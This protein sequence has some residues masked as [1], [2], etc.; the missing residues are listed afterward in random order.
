M[1]GLE[2]LQH[3]WLNID[4]RQIDLHFHRQV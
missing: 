1:K 3:L 2:N 4:K